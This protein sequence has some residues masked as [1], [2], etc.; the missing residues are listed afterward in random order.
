MLASSGGDGIVGGMR[1][2]FLMIAM[3]VLVGCGATPESR[4]EELGRTFDPIIGLS[5]TRMV[6]LLGPP[7]KTERLDDGSSVAT[8]R[9]SVTWWRYDH[10]GV[11]VYVYFDKNRIAVRWAPS[12]LDSP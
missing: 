3:V 5:H 8:Y 2:I 4:K 12:N 1:Q 6:N 11:W 10:F 7:I 9:A